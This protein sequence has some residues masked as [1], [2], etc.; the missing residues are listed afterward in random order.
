MAS[1]G[2]LPSWLNS[3]CIFQLVL[4][5]GFAAHRTVHSNSRS[6]PSTIGSPRRHLSSTDRF[7]GFRAHGSLVGHGLLSGVGVVVMANARRPRR[8]F[9]SIRKPNGRRPQSTPFTLIRLV[10]FSSPI[11][12]PFCFTFNDRRVG[13]AAYM[14]SSSLAT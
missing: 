13:P 3:T 14:L 2:V 1:L 5:D 10:H 12:E 6:T 7:S 8:L 4:P 9:A 11:V